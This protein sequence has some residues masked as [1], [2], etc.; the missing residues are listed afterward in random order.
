MKDININ[1]RDKNNSTNS[2]PSINERD[3]NNWTNF[4]P[5]IHNSFTQ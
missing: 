3:K 2:F 5:L 4:L 1:E